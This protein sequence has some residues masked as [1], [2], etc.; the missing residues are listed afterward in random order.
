[1]RRSIVLFSAAYLVCLFVQAGVAGRHIR[2]EN[3]TGWMMD[4]RQIEVY[5]GGTNIV[6]N[7]GDM[8][9]GTVWPDHDVKTRDGRGMTDGVL[10]PKQRGIVFVDHFDDTTGEKG[11]NPWFEVDLG[12]SVDIERVILCGSRW[13]ERIYLDKGH[14]I[15]SIIGE[16]RKVVWAEKFDYYD[17]KRCNEGLFTFEPKSG[18]KNPAVGMQIPVNGSCW[19][20]M[21]WLMNADD[22]PPLP[23]AAERMARFAKRNSKAEAKELADMFFPLLD[24]RIPELKEAHKLYARGK[25]QDALDAWKVYWFA[26]M[27]LVNLHWA[28]RGDYWTYP[29]NGDELVDGIGVTISATSARAIRF[30][31]GQIHWIDL[32]PRGDPGFR[33]AMIDAQQ[34]AEVNKMARPLLDA[35]MNNPKPAYIQRWSEIMDDWSINFFEDARKC[36]YEVENLFT[37]NPGLAWQKMMED[38]SDLAVKH[39][40]MVD[41]L[42]STTLARVQLVC[43]EKYTTAWWRQT[44]ET[45]FNHTNGGIC[46]YYQVSFYIDEFYPG[47]RTRQEFQQAFERLMTLATERDGSLTEIGDEGHQEIP[48]HQ[49]SFL[50]HFEQTRPDWF[51]PGWRNRAFE[52]YDNLFTYMLR[53]LA[54]GGY[55]HRFAVDYR[56]AR[57]TSTHKQYCT[58][59]LWLPP[60]PDR[61]KAVFGVPEVRR[62]LDAWGHISEGRPEVTDPLLK[63]IIEKQQRSHD[64]VKAFLGDEK[65]GKPHINSDWMP[66]TGAYYFRGGWNEQDAFMGMMACTSNGGSQAPQWPYSMIYHYD[67]NYPL[68]AVNPIHIDGLQPQQL[69]GRMNCFQPG[70]KTMALT[71]AVDD[72]APLRWISS[73]RF[74][75]GEA[76]FQGG[77]QNY[78]GF[79]GDWDG[80]D[81]EQLDAGRYVDKV[82]TIRQVFHLRASRLFIVLDASRTPS[83]VVHEFTVP[84]II[85]LSERKKDASKPFSKEQLKIDVEHNLIRSENPDGPSV[86]LY[87]FADQPIQYQPDRDAN[88]DYRKYSRRLGGEI[89][90]AEQKVNV[91]LKGNDVSMVTLVSSSSKGEQERVGDVQQITAPGTVGFNTKLRDGSEIWFQSAGM[92]TNDLACGPCKAKGQALLAVKTQTEVS[93]ILL[94]GTEL[95]VNGRRVKFNNPD[96][97]FVVKDGKLWLGDILRPIDPVRFFP[98]RNVF[99]DSETVTM[100][101]RTPNVEI[102]YTTDGTPPTRKS[103][104]Y[105][106]PIKITESTEFAARVYRLG[107]DGKPMSADE[108]EINGT[109]FTVP[110]YGWFYKKPMMPAVKQ[111]GLKPGLSYEYVEAPWWR[112]YASAHWLPAEKTGEAAREMDLSSVTT[113]DYYCMRYKGYINIP[114]DGVYTFHAPY[115]F[116][117]MDCATSY[118]LRV[119]VDNEEW[120]LTQW[121]HGRGT[122]SAALE[123]G[124]HKFQV[125][126]ADARSKPWRRSGIWRYYPRPWSVY[127]G[128]PS[129]INLT[130]P[131]IEKPTRIPSAWLSYHP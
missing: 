128:N 64:E 46:L 112:L 30:T 100:V 27:K 10:D 47:Q 113:S 122:W 71:Q 57:W 53:H 33:N 17:A 2:V 70:T 43:M 75:F 35:Y 14:R 114:A 126:F 34:K 18:E 72:P 123:A 99:V 82:R 19:T 78:P 55:E 88:I 116:V 63:D 24:N 119:F 6:R 89:G 109:K 81:L 31:P 66:Y 129:D 125:D 76:D 73:D 68:V 127:K 5:S 106:K 49:G 37:F 9:S 121:R 20:P 107:R 110:S 50:T 22:I 101:S 48:I 28:F 58:D 108:F 97:Q 92:K 74:D 117:N 80:P 115:E 90:I 45:V 21:S 36:P 69:F 23:D 86:A 91:K 105:V 95:L 93:G 124:L 4:W 61:D 26:K 25:Y 13:P 3:P 15:I 120:Y 111:S 7:H 118:D 130:G 98:C 94:D 84:T 79:K 1:M 59:R 103:S 85:S 32:P 11:M 40:Q 42:P 96:I 41:I 39:P 77:Y 16:D 104:L 60:L 87:Q 54:P 29:T 83:D 62:M 102:R 67:Y 12:Q 51:T 131:G 52:W 8:F 65:P 38:L 44:R 56:P